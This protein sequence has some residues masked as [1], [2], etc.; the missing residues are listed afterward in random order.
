M[1]G[2]AELVR[3]GM[4]KE[5]IETGQRDPGTSSTLAVSALFTVELE[6]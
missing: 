3:D 1:K 2:H 4:R 5:N 6:L